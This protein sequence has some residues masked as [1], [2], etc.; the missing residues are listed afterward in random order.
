M[1]DVFWIAVLSLCSSWYD[2]IVHVKV[3]V[4]DVWCPEDDNTG[5]LS[6][7]VDIFDRLYLKERPISLPMVPMI[8]I[9]Q[10]YDKWDY[11]R[12]FDNNWSMWKCWWIIKILCFGYPPLWK[13]SKNRKMTNNMFWWML[14]IIFLI[15]PFLHR[16]YYLFSQNSESSLEQ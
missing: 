1:S 14:K 12:K 11:V 8:T 16:E 3:V 9:K 4:Y 13:K 6:V 7:G 10:I 5:F 2:I 15:Y